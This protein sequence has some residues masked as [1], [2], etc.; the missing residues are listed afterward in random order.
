MTS[1]GQRGSVLME[2]FLKHFKDLS[3][4]DERWLCDVFEGVRQQL[5]PLISSSLSL[6]VVQLTLAVLSKIQRSVSSDDTSL[7]LSYRFLSVSELTREQRTACCSSLSW[8]SAHYREQARRAEQALPNHRALPRDNLLLIGYLCDGRD[9]GASDGVWRVRDAGESVPCEM[10][11]SSP[12]WLGRLMLF[13]TWNYIPQNAPLRGEN[14]AG[15]LELIG[16][17]VCVTPEPMTF[18]PGGSLSEVMSVKRAAELLKQ[19]CDVQVQV[20]VSGQ[21]SVVC[22]LLVISGK[23]FFCLILSEGGSSVPVLITE[24]KH[25]Y[26][27]RCVCVGQSVCISALRVCSLR[28]WAEHPVLSVTRQSRLHPH[29]QPQENSEDTDTHA[30][31]DIQTHTPETHLSSGVASSSAPSVRRKHS[32][33]ISYKGVITKILNA[34][35]GLYEIDKKVWLCLAYQPVQKWG[36]GLRPGAEIQLHNVHFLF[37]PS[38]FAADVVLCACLRSSVR[39]ITFSC[40][41]SKVEASGSHSPLQCQLL[42]KNLSASQFLW[43]SYC[44]NAVKERLCPRWVRPE[45]VCVVAGRLLDCVCDAEQKTHTKR[46][47]YTEMLQEPHMCPVT[48]YCVCWPCAVLW[49]VKQASD[50]MISEVWASLSLSSL[51]PPAAAHMTSVELNA[52]LS[53][54]VHTVPLAE[55]V[56]DPVLLVGILELD[57]TRATLQLRD[58]THTL[59]CVCVQTNQSGARTSDINTAWLGC[60]VCVRRCTLVMERFM[61]TDFPSWKNT[62]QLSY[63][64]HKH[65]RVYLQLCVNDLIIISPSASMSARLTV[66]SS[67]STERRD[68]QDDSGETFNRR[69]TAKRL[70]EDDA[71]DDVSVAPTA[72]RP[73]T[74]CVS[75]VFRLESKQ[76]VTF[77]NCSMSG[78]AHTLQLAFVVRATCLGDVQSWSSDPKNCRIRVRERDGARTT[79]ELHF[80]EKCVRWFPVLHPGTVYRLITLNTEDVSVLKAESVSVRGG[81]KLL[82]S[83]ALLMQPQWRIHT[84]TEQPPDTQAADVPSLMTV[85]EVLHSSSTLEIISF[86]GVISQRITLQQE[87]ATKPS[88]PSVTAAKDGNTE[89]DLKVRLTVQDCES[90]GQFVQVYV[91]L[92]CGPYTPG[93]IAG[94]TVLLH[95]FQRKVSRVCNVY[96]RSLPISCVTVTGLGPDNSRSLGCQSSPPMML[97]GEWASGRTQQCVVAEVKGHVVCVLSLRLQWTCSLCGSVFKQSSC[98]RTHPACDSN[99]AVFQ[100]EAKVVLE[101]GSAEAQVWFSSDTISDLLMLDAAQWEGLQRH[102]RVKGLVRVYIRGWNMMCDVDPDDYLVQ[103]LCCLCSSNTVCRQIH[104]TCRQQ[105][106]KTGKS[107]LR[108]VCRGLTEFISR[109][110]PALQLHCTHIHTHTL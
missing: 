2:E 38:P 44:H 45:R 78:D 82:S 70:R 12:L 108:K 81:V 68:N 40:L 79:M 24:V 55:A 41:S 46:D 97:L 95:H 33:L 42:E 69:E 28:G 99:S 98:T 94:A 37:R 76:G 91:D 19:R 15:Y 3:R 83:P 89:R 10:L 110:T 32:T 72:K 87:N 62:D 67:E 106:Q 53:W 14:T 93:L 57:S 63:I 50:W 90:A 77:R 29:V 74:P 71:D 66:V 56:S 59:D 1:D 103:Y 4:A 61:K 96:C 109:F 65:C 39:I 13:P 11:K 31:M 92:S 23:S 17:P 9:V 75:V 47:I 35:A 36:G 107:H 22:P 49:S 85:S 80:T 73:L 6:S 100:A 5:Y 34:E 60:L 51:L 8:S 30:V 26:W 48:T 27:Q 84:L 88:I 64:T 18:D 101:D 21:V 104:L 52:A 43:L 16:S 54:S 7:P 86:Y 102:V 20:C 58:Q 105:T 25:Q